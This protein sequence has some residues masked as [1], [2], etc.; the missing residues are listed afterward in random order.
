M[1]PRQDYI[2]PL[3]ELARDAG[4]LLLSYFGKVAIEY[5]GDADLV[6]QADRS[7]EELI[8]GRIRKEWPEHDLI[9]EEGSRT[10]TGSDFRW[11]LDP[12]DG[13]TNFAHGYPVFC[14]SM[15]LEYKNELIAGVV[16][17]PT[18]DE[19]FVAEKGSGARLN[20][21][22]IHVSRTPQVAQSLLGTGFPSHKR[23][24]NPNI[25]FYHQITLRSHGVRRAGSAALDLCCVACGRYDGF[26]EFNLN[27][28]DTAAGVLLVREAG[29]SV[30]DFAGGPAGVEGRDLIA[31]NGLLHAEL[32]GE[33][34]QIFAGR[35]E[36]LPSPAEYLRGR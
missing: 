14:V 15:G 21:K 26:W 25:H 32:L 10:E 12:L 1:S 7:C 9:A 28:W 36:G 27:S 8:V 17:D 13:T 31:T 33:F 11:H 3:Q 34:Q 2:T 35:I 18:R 6:T 5:K 24:K 22:T 16:Y 30:T 20:G 4:S 19:M 23:H 29:G